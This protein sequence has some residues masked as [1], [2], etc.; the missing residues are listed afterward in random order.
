M[1]TEHKKYLPLLKLLRKMKGSDVSELLTHLNDESINTI[2]ESCY[3]L[4]YNDLN[5]TKQK[6]T[7]LKR[8]I[9]SNCSIHR[10]K[11][12]SS[13]NVPI[14]KR[15]RCLIQEGKGLPLLLASVIPFITD[16]IFGK[17]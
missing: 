7:R 1:V 4:L 9:K 12:I 17:K 10:L 16:L 11:K 3:N 15:R 13:K 2:C 8:F 6:K 14:S 5:L